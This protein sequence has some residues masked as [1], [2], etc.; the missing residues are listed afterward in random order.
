MIIGLPS[1]LRVRR[2]VLALVL[3]LVFGSAVNASQEFREWTDVAGA[4]L[5]ADYI[6]RVDSEIWLISAQGTLV[7]IRPDELSQEDLRYL[8]DLAAADDA[9][10]QL[11]LPGTG[12]IIAHNGPDERALLAITETLAPP[13]TAKALTLGEALAQ[14][15]RTVR[16]HSEPG[17]DLHIRLNDPKLEPQALRISLSAKPVYASLEA[18]ARAHQLPFFIRD[19]E[20]VLGLR[21]TPR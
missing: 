3:A 15:Q 5:N 18:I 12:W 2:L 4:T 21:D 10:R 9:N 20:V 14:L 13:L 8:D 19:G 1:E 11:G 7:K 6:G 16:R 17:W